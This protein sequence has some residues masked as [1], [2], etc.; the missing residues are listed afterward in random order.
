MVAL[1]KVALLL[2]CC[3][4]F[5]LIAGCRRDHRK[6]GYE[7]LPD[8]VHPVPYESFSPNPNTAD[9][10]TLQRPVAGTIPRGFLPYPFPKDREKAGRYLHNPLPQTKDVL[11]RGKH[12]YE[13]FCLVCHGVSGKGDG[14]LIPKFPNPPSLTS[15]SVRSLPEGEIYHVITMGSGQMKAYASQIEASDRWKLVS[16]V[17]VLQSQ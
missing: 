2:V 9:G 8:M 12:M 15:K 5:L 14:P 6:R 7:F 10:K 4:V 17:R 1:K 3:T 13:T 11:A 16:Y